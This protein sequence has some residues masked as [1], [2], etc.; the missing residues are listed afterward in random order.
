MGESLSSR[1]QKKGSFSGSHMRS[2]QEIG[3]ETGSCIAEKDRKTVEQ[4]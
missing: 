3:K 1:S 2:R 4:V